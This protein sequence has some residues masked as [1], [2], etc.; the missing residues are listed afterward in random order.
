MCHLMIL[1]YVSHP[2]EELW[3]H[4]MI[5]LM[6]FEQNEMLSIIIFEYKTYKMICR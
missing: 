1:E 5:I 3:K 4:Y 6:W 2:V